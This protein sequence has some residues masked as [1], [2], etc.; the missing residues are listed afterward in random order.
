MEPHRIHRIVVVLAA[1]ALRTRS[2]SERAS[3][4]VCARDERRKKSAFG[5]FAATLAESIQARPVELATS[6]CMRG[7][8]VY[9]TR[10]RRGERY[11][12]RL[13]A[14]IATRRDFHRISLS[15]FLNAEAMRVMRAGM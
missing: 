3:E 14:T 9:L 2:Q 6:R 13:K 15:G 7:V 8:R 12:P 11:V 1:A 5:A 4:R 10:F